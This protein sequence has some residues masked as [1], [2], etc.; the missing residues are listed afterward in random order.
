[1]AYLNPG[2]IEAGGGAP[3]YGARLALVAHLIGRTLPKELREAWGHPHRSWEANSVMPSDIEDFPQA[4]PQ[5]ATHRFAKL[6]HARGLE[7]HGGVL[8]P[9]QPEARKP[10]RALSGMRL[11]TATSDT[12]RPDQQPPPNRSLR[13]ARSKTPTKEKVHGADRPEPP[14][15]VARESKN[16]LETGSEGRCHGKECCSAV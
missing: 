5:H 3:Y 13:N 14:P 7:A 16:S 11:W 8:R 1:M 9:G 6:H 15:C 4:G 12:S 2:I 10:Q